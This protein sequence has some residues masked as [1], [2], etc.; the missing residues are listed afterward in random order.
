MVTQQIRSFTVVFLVAGC[1]AFAVAYAHF[2]IRGYRAFALSGAKDDASLRRA[3]AL[4]PRNASAYNAYCRFQRDTQIDFTGALPSCQRAV[5]LNGNDSANWLDLAE[6][7]YVTGDAQAERVALEQAI[8]ADPMTPE[9]A[10]NAGNLYL[11]Q[12]QVQP[13]SRLFSM[14]LKG[15]PALAPVALKTSWRAFGK[16]DPILEMLPPDAT[17]YLQFVAL[18]ASEN[19]REAASQVWDKMIGLGNEINYKDA[20]FYTN[21]LLTWWQNV[22]AAEKAWKQLAEVSPSFRVY[23]PALPNLVVNS[24]FEQEILNAGFDWRLASD[25]T[26]LTIDDDTFKTGGHSALVTYSTPVLDSGLYQMVPVSPNSAYKASAWLRT[27]ELQTA[28]GPRLA[29]T[30]AYS[31][32]ILGATEPVAYTTPWKQVT[33]DFKTGPDMQLVAVRFVRDRQDTV[34]RGRLWIDDVELRALPQASDVQIKKRT[35]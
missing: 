1:F 16:V 5:E 8:A 24:G 10:W 6:V 15:D 32:A 35:D 23:Q 4:E 21:D 3:M 7:L 11:L 17:A 27:D 28:N 14:V 19:Q 20:L 2:A 22:T 9:V 31:G 30:D 33:V 18:L 13:A 12:G 29:V 26:K 34:I 25:G